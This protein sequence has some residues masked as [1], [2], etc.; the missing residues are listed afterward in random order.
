MILATLHITAKMPKRASFLVCLIIVVGAAL[1]ATQSQAAH[2]S[3]L[4][5]F[6][7]GN[8]ISDSLFFNKNSMSVSDIQNFLNQRVPTCDRWGTKIYSGSQTRAQYGASRGYPAPYTCLKDYY[9][10]PTTRA[11][12]LNGNPIPSGGISA[13]QMIWNVSQEFNISPEVML[14]TLQKE[15]LNLMGDDWPWPSQY[16]VPMG[17][18]CPDTAPCDSQYFGFYNQVQKAA[19]QFRR[20]ATYPSQY[21]YKSGQNNSIQF[22]PN[23]ACGSSNVYIENQATAGLY[24]Y[25][26]YQ[27]NQ[28]AITAGYGEANCGAYGNRNFWLYYYT[29]F[30]SSL[31]RTTSS[32]TVYLIVDGNKYPI[33]DINVLN[34]YSA[35]GPVRFVNDTYIANKTTGPTLGHMVGGPTSTIY[36]VASNIKLPFTSCDQVIDYG[37]TCSNII[38]LT[39]SQLNKL[40]SGPNITNRYI[41]RSGRDFYMSDGTKR[42][43]FSTQALINNS[44]NTSSVTL[45]DASINYL[46]YGVPVTRNNSLVISRQDGKKYLL[47]TTGAV[48]L[49]SDI[50]NQSKFK[51]LRSSRYDNQSI[52]NINS[53]EAGFVG[54]TQNS[55]GDKF[56]LDSSGKIPIADEARWTTAYP[57]LDDAFLDLIPNSSRSID[58]GFI[59]SD[60]K[61]TLYNVINKNK[62]SVTSWSDFINLH[63][64]KSSSWTGLPNTTV[65]S[66]AGGS[67]IFAPGALIKSSG[68]ATVY[69]VNG[70][71][72]KTP[73]GSFSVSNDIGL[74]GARVVD[75]TSLNAHTTDNTPL[76]NFIICNS[77]SYL[78]NRGTLYEIDANTETMYGYSTPVG[79]TWDTLGCSNL[80]ISGRPLSDFSFIKSTSGNTIYYLDSGQKRPIG[81]MSKYTELGGGN[82]NLLIVST[83]VL[84]TVPDGSLVN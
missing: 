3:T 7:P 13:A 26:P 74:G 54:F 43:V 55:L 66:I 48:Y 79:Q 42:E 69:V 58:H 10:N 63:L 23:V 44:L 46:P 53:V 29:W 22:N 38:K 82:N 56:V 6:R 68:S 61:S 34:D 8:I 77:R 16:R 64:D 50:A 37:Y 60:A 51:S 4:G 15:S 2:A 67:S 76:S 20:Y 1:F 35:L 5:S 72:S 14:V 71:L 81:S 70:L 17:Y 47:Q 78:A 21:R 25:T 9:E 27:P 30:G 59:K 18:A 45:Q 65:S 83:R 75:N 40:S 24:N 12:N 49:P 73:L 80:K 52:Q 57:A 84:G 33:A 11:N 62:H 28:G 41:T 19:Y 32:S 39:Q 31:V 36:F